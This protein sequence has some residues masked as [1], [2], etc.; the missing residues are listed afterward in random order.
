[1]R[2]IGEAAGLSSTSSVSYQLTVLMNKGLLRRDPKRPRAYSV[3]SPGEAALGETDWA[4]PY[5]SAAGEEA[6][7]STV[8]APLVGQ[9]AAGVPITAEQHIADVLAVP[10]QL[11]G[12]GDMFA[13]TVKGDSM[14]GAHIVDG[15]TVII[16]QQE[17]AEH[18]EI[19]AAMLDSE[20]TVKRLKLDGAHVWLVAENP[21]YP[22]LSG[23]DATILGKVVTVMRSL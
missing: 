3:T 5:T 20:A 4:Y 19:V 18:G 23:D 11:T 7:S 1:M 21:A 22:P 15:D 14:T 10:R 8:A 12:S 16:R 13:L 6:A 9:I 2:E 17:T